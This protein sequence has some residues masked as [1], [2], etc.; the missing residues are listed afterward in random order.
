MPNHR[1]SFNCLEEAAGGRLVC[2]T[3][4][5]EVTISP[6][7]HWEERYGAAEASARHI[8]KIRKA[9]EIIEVWEGPVRAG[10]YGQFS[11]GKDSLK[12]ITVYQSDLSHHF[13]AAVRILDKN[14]KEFLA[15]LGSEDAKT[16]LPQYRA[17]WKKHGLKRTV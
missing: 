11:A 15:P 14:G 13:E 9:G 12:R 17:Q 5:Q 8:G 1:H 2:S 3:L 6:T 10:E 7:A 16:R 4:N